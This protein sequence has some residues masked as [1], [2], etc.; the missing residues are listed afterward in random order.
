MLTTSD[1]SAS[2]WLEFSRAE[3]LLLFVLP[4]VRFLKLL[5]YFESFRLLVE[6]SPARRMVFGSTFTC[7]PGGTWILLVVATGCNMARCVFQTLKLIVFQE[8]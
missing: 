5:R 2:S 4:V 8:P 6:T 7:Q 3:V 1:L